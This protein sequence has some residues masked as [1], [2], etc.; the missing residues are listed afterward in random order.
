MQNRD[1]IKRKITWRKQKGDIYN[2]Q[3][4]RILCFKKDNSKTKNELLEIKTLES[5]SLLWHERLPDFKTL[6]KRERN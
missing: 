6:K 4:N 5:L 2:P 3:N 1:H